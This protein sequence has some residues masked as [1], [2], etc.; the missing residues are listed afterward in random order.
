MFYNVQ[1]TL[2]RTG[3]YWQVALNYVILVSLIYIK[4]A[5]PSGDY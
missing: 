5:N 1:L 2:H 4:I 3:K